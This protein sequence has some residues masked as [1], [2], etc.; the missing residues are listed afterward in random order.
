MARVPGRCWWLGQYVRHGGGGCPSAVGIKEDPEG[1][2]DLCD[3]LVFGEDASGGV[4]SADAEGREVDGSCGRRAWTWPGLSG[5]PRRLVNEPARVDPRS[6]GLG[7]PAGIGTTQ[8]LDGAAIR[9]HGTPV[10]VRLRRA[11]HQPAGDALGGVGD[12]Q[13]AVAQ[14]DVG[15]AQCG[16]FGAAQLGQG[17]GCGGVGGTHDDGHSGG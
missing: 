3:V 15:S 5:R 12:L 17:A 16:G 7:L 6:G 8:L 9:H 2:E 4:A 14:V 1:A 11:L 10:G 13:H